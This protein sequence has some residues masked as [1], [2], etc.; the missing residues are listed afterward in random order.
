MGTVEVLLS[1][2]GWDGM[3][4][5]RDFGINSLA[6][7][8]SLEVIGVE[9]EGAL[10]VDGA[11]VDAEG[12][13]GADALEVERTVDAED[14]EGALLVLFP[15]DVDLPATVSVFASEVL[16]LFCCKRSLQLEALVDFV[17]VESR[18]SCF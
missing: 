5:E 9:V 7:G 14:A 18:G 12:A 16:G 17:A 10:E 13:E 11:V 15:L 3:A 4:V 2:D 1:K 6:N 8:L